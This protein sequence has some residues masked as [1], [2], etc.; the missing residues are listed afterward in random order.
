MLTTGNLG[1]KKPEGTDVV[2]IMDFNANADI[3]DN[4]VAGK[5]DKEAGKQLSTN[6]FT[7][8]EK[9]KL[10][11]V[12]AG[13]NAY[14]HPSSHP[15][16]IIV[17]DASNRFVT[18]SEKA[19]WSAKANTA[20]ATTST[21]GLQSAADK[22]KLDGIATGANNYIHPSSHAASMITIADT[23]NLIAGTNVETALQEIA[24]SVFIKVLAA[25]FN[26][27]T[28]SVTGR[29]YAYASATNIPSVDIYYI[30]HFQSIDAGFASQQAYNL[31]NNRV[32][33]RR[34]YNGTWTSWSQISNETISLGN[35][36][37]LNNVVNSGE[38]YGFDVQ[39]G[40]IAN[41]SGYLKV[42]QH[43]NDSSYLNQTYKDVATSSTWSRARVNNVWQPWLQISSEMVN[44]GEG[45]DFNNIIKDGW[46]HVGSTT[47]G[48]I[49]GGYF[50]LQVSRF[51]TQAYTVQN[52]YAT[53]NNR[54]WT[55][56]QVSGTWTVWSPL[57]TPYV[58]PASD[59]IYY[60]GDGTPRFS[61][62][63]ISFRAPIKGRY[64]ISADVALHGNGG[65]LGR[66]LVYAYIDSQW[67]TIGNIVGGGNNFVYSRI[68]HDMNVEVAE[69]G[70]IRVGVGNGSDYQASIKNLYIQGLVNAQF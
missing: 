47:N 20:A 42:T 52:A 31:I 11:G 46:F 3:L 23:G 17:Q 39:A 29:Y 44:L 67:V 48:P 4:A 13:A 24:G 37:N 43:P 34:N 60:S 62:N 57:H 27:N 6:D 16:S 40:P 66:L 70:S 8:A 33:T 69:F 59:T 36:P 56:R 2:D 1:L 35:Q 41:S 9:T 49:A 26:M 12:A 18:D 61:G 5:V 54:V 38:F 58:Y 65:S 64:R 30:D 51:P 19:A 21:A 7:T 63:E 53:E 28:L 50:F 32:Y 55:R 22:T 14:V 15:A 45:I 10:A 68:T 25:G